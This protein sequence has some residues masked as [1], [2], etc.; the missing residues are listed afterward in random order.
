MKTK[1]L[2]PI[3]YGVRTFSRTEEKRKEHELE[4][5]D[6]VLFNDDVNTFN[7]VIQT[8]IDVCDHDPIQAE[9]C[10]HIV[11]HIGKCG[12]KRGSYEELKPKCE[13]LLDKGLSATIVSG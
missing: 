11:H 10:A 1:L 6:I 9:Q 3:K 7:F 2:P 13:A 5:S 8:L 4:L 12:V